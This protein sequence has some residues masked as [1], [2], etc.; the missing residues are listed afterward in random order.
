L[1]LRQQLVE[2]DPNSAAEQTGLMLA[3][4]RCGRHREAVEIADQLRR[5]YQD[6]SHLLYF[7]ATGYAVCAETVAENEEAAG[8]EQAELLKH[9][10]RLAVET[11]RSAIDH[12][13]EVTAELELDP[14]LDGIRDRP[15]FRELLKARETLASADPA[16]A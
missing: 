13:Y 3:L 15:D 16:A 12:G 2:V 11:L 4:G 1:R 10:G 5:S 6:E 7:V 8:A 14:D 9:Y